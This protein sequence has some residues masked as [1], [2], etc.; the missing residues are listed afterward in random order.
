ML[1]LLYNNSKQGSTTFHSFSLFPHLYTH[2]PTIKYKYN[3]GLAKVKLILSYC[4]AGTGNDDDLCSSLT[5]ILYNTCTS[6][7][8]KN[9][10]PQVESGPAD[11][12]DKQLWADGGISYRKAIPRTCG[13][14]LHGMA[15]LR[16]P[17]MKRNNQAM[18]NSDPISKLF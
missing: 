1:Y 7:K 18:Q 4:R 11:Q 6:A 10:Y 2:T 12:T 17:A 9:A 14:L 5:D 13:M 16:P 3:H 8:V 15:H